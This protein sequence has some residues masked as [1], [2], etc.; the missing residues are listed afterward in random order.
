MSTDD[1][2]LR[3]LY[4]AFERVEYRKNTKT[5]N[6][7]K[8]ISDDPGPAHAL[9]VGST[10]EGDPWQQRRFGHVALQPTGRRLPHFYEGDGPKAPCGA[11]VKVVLPMAVDAED[12]DVCEECAEL[13]RSGQ[14]VGRWGRGGGAGWDRRCSA[15]LRQE[16][17]GA[18]VLHE[19]T[20]R[21][22]HDGLHRD[23]EGATW[24]TGP[25]DF[26]PPPDGFV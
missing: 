4:L 24:E 3:P 6:R 20:R 1:P 16:E 10:H 13:V 7:Y 23:L 21:E 5:H 12:P 17:G 18:M 15:F 8:K 14:A 9:D 25:E 2:P 11:R 19:C 26:T 22:Y